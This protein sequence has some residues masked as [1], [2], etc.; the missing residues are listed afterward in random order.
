MGLKL[1]S[2]K[3]TDGNG[4]RT[5]T[6][7]NFGSFENKNNYRKPNALQKKHILIGRETNEVLKVTQLTNK[8]ESV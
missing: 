6:G 3:I 5:M 1:V 4:V 8:S 2:S 7:S